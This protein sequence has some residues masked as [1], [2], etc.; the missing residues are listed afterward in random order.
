[1]NSPLESHEVRLRGLGGQ[2][3]CGVPGTRASATVRHGGP[4]RWSE[5]KTAPM[6]NLFNLPQGFLGEVRA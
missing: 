3:A 2:A 4:V 1:M 6:S 5:R